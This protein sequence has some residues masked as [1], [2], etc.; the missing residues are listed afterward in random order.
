MSAQMWHLVADALSTRICTYHVPTRPGKPLTRSKPNLD[1]SA[2]AL[3][4]YQNDG[5]TEPFEG[6]ERF[7]L[8]SCCDASSVAAPP[9]RAH[10][11]SRAPA[12]PNRP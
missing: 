6:S 12:R 4:S 10:R 2:Q 11:A 7:D 3:N 5:C 1:L 9:P 8:M